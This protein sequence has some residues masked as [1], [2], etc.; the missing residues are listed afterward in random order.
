MREV[1]GQVSGF[2]NAGLVSV[3]LPSGYR[4]RG[5]IPGLADLAKRGLLD[6]RAQQ[7]VMRLAAS[8]Y[9]SEAPDEAESDLQAMA[10]SYVAGF[11]REA[12]DPG[13][14]E[15]KPVSLT[16]EDLPNLDQ[17][18]RAQLEMLVLRMSTAEAITARSLAGEEGPGDDDLAEFRDGSDSVAGGD[19]GEGVEREAVGAAGGA[20]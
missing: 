6:T 1:Q 14:D 16:V 11:P 2:G 20:G 8:R 12:Q 5:V 15:W 3:L 4:V 17:R 19:D 13:D 18:D 7:A 10:D 9:I